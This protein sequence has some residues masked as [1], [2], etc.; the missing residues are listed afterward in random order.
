MIPTFDNVG[1][2]P[3]V[4]P[5][6]SQI[7][8]L[9]EGIRLPHAESN[10]VAAKAIDEIAISA[11]EIAVRLSF[12]YPLSTEQIAELKA[13]VCQALQTRWNKHKV[14]TTINIRLRRHKVQGALKPK[15]MIKNIIAVG[16]GKGGVGKSTVAV[17]L[18][19]AL[20]A[21]GAK[22]ALLDADIYGPSQPLLLGRA[23]EKAFT[24]L[25]KLIPIEQYG[26]QSISMGYLV[27]EATPMVWRGPM[28]SGALQQLLNDTAWRECDYMII[29]LPPGTGDIQLTLA[30]KIPISGAIIVTTPQDLALIDVRKAYHM[31]AKVGV[32]VLGVVENMSTH[33]CSQCGHHDP[34]FGQGG[35][36]AIAKECEINFLGQ[37]P[38]TKSVREYADQGT[39]IVNAAPL[40]PVSLTYQS[41][42]QKA[43]MLLS[44]R[45]VEHTA[46][47]SELVLEG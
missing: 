21:L 37:I 7:T 40:D 20:Q 45:E 10:L 8:S 9:L 2:M 26:I 6:P 28:V 30:Q 36:E 15:S 22:V 41:I 44:K 23:R 3:M 43:A 35:G 32:P 16:S 42:A 14:V 19:C 11:D 31:F 1:K 38:L 5:L 46:V 27:D 13:Q 29:D 34:I 39:P 4:A 33:V 17:N 12:G 18:A 25:K 24:H 47:L